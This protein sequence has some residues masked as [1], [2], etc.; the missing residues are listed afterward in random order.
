[1]TEINRYAPPN[2]TVDEPRP[3]E[4]DAPELATRWQRFCAAFVDGIIA[5]IIACAVL[6]PTYGLDS[7]AALGRAP[8]MFLGGL[9][10]DYVIYCAIQAWF[11]YTSSQTIG[12]R[13]VG[14]RI[15]R[16]DN[17]HADIGR[18]L[19]RL[20]IMT[21]SGLI[22][23]I[24]KIFGLVDVLFIFSASRRCLHDHIAGTI[25]VTAASS[26][27]ASLEATRKTA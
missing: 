7:M 12:K 20:A 15:V 4:S 13:V 26:M 11:L 5:T 14:L 1:M 19:L 23:L 17:T 16:P 9:L 22:P 8:S 18:L 10:L 2:A 6:I 3:L 24:G 25:V 27:N 21:F